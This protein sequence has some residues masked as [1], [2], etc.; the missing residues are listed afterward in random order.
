MI[1]LIIMNETIII[2]EFYQFISIFSLLLFI[3]KPSIR[4]NY[5]IFI[6][7]CYYFIVKVIE[8]K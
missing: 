2:E 7:V 6:K 8:N 5:F 3:D 1:K 4:I